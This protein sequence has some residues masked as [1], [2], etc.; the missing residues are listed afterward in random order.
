MH[1]V[2]G[3][4]WEL[5]KEPLAYTK[6]IVWEDGTKQHLGQM[7]RVAVLQD[8]NGKVTHLYFATMDGKG[9]FSRGTKS[10]NMVVPLINDKN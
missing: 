2:D 6:D 10:W 7:E 1:S 8:E 4:K 5:D 9:G 3:V